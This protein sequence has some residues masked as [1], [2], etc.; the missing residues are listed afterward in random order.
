MAAITQVVPASEAKVF[1]ILENPDG[2]YYIWVGQSIVDHD[3]AQQI[4]EL[5]DTTINPPVPEE[6]PEETP[7]DEEE[8]NG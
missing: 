2:S 7:E 4:C 8:S 3:T 1:E 5:I 6:V